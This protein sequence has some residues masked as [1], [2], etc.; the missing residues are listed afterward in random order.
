MQALTNWLTKL[1][2]ALFPTWEEKLQ[3]LQ[4]NKRAIFHLKKLCELPKDQRIYVE[5]LVGK[6]GISPSIDLLRDMNFVSLRVENNIN[7]WLIRATKQGRIALNALEQK[8][9]L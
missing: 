5:N 8:A 2:Q 1:R 4:N 3:K 6:D 9:I 7:K